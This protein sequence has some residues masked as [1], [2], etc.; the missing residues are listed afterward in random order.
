MKADVLEL[1]SSLLSAQRAFDQWRSHRS[2]RRHTPIEL[3]R[4][5]VALLEYHCAFHVCRALRI[6]AVAL[7]R[8]ASE[9]SGLQAPHGRE[10]DAEVAAGFVELPT[11]IEPPMESGEHALTEVIIELPNAAVVRA[12]GSFTLDALLKAAAWIPDRGRALQ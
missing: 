11:V 12:R 6:N 7:K 9:Q 3:Q 1:N 10:G 5:A 2:A 4:R 8:W